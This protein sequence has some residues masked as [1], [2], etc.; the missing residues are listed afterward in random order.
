MPWCPSCDRFLSPPTV[1][2]DGTCPA[3]GQAVEA[4]PPPNRPLG[5]NG[6]PR[7]GPPSEEDEDLPAVPPH[8]KVLGG[9]IVVY[10]GWR[11]VQGVEWLI[12]RI[13]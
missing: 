3:C 2:P 8:L 12:H 7:A 5:P 4:A 10:L 9:A 6:Q 13:P 11:L 1:N